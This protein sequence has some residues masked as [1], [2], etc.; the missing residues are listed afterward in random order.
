MKTG[1]MQDIVTLIRDVVTLIDMRLSEENFEEKL[2]DGEDVW[3]KGDG[4]FAAMTCVAVT[5]KENTAIIQGWLK[6]SR[7][8]EM[9]L[10][11]VGGGKM[12]NILE[13][14]RSDIEKRVI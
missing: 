12:R 6:S 8:G 14:I 4:V 11:G 2:V 1:N 9:S 13:G 3:M 7:L 5:F 10:D